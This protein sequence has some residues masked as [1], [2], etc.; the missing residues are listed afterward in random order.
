[1]RVKHRKATQRK[2]RGRPQLGGTR[3]AVRLS[4]QTAGRLSELASFR[5]V[6]ANL[7]VERAL[8]LYFQMLVDGGDVDQ[9]RSETP[10]KVLSDIRADEV[11]RAF[12]NGVPRG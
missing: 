3:V 9:D 6:P 10:L 2:R 7:I 8:E 11:I 12:S 4:Q 1:M 5:T